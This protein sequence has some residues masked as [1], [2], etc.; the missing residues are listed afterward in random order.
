MTR[1]HYA[2]TVTAKKE[3]RDLAIFAFPLKR[4]AHLHSRPAAMFRAARLE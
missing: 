1:A 3:W 2:V 4:E